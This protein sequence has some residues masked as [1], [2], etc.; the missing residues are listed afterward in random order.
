MQVRQSKYNPCANIALVHLNASTV[1]AKI[2]PDSLN[3]IPGRPD[4]E[5]SNLSGRDA[6]MDGA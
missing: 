6:P 2:A 1:H 4:P 5:I 3:L